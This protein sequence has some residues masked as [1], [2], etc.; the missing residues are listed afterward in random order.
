MILKTIMLSGAVAGLV[1]MGP[2]LC[3]PELHKYGDTFPTGHRLHRHRHRPAR[4]QQPGRHRL[5]RARVG[6]LERGGAGPRRRS[7]CP[8]RSSRSCRA[9][10]CSPSSSPSRWCAATPAPPP[11]REAAAQTAARR[12]APAA[13]RR[14]DH[15]RWLA[16]GEPR[17][18]GAAAWLDEPAGPRPLVVRRR[19]PSPSCR[20]SRIIAD[21][22]DLTQR[23]HVRRRH[24]RLGADRAGRPRRPLVRAGR[25]RQHRPR[26][27][28][29]PRHLVRRLGRLAVGPV[30]GARC[31]GAIGGALGGAAPRPRHGH[32]RRRPHRRPASPST[33]SRPASAGSCRACC[34]SA[35]GDGTITQSPHMT[36]D[37]G[38]LTVP[39]LSGGSFFGWTRPTR[40][41]GSTSN[42]GSSS[43]TSPA[44][45]RASPPSMAWTTV[46]A[47]AAD[48]AHGLRAVAHARSGC[49]C[50]P[51]AR[52]RAPPTRSA[53]PSTAM[54][55]VGRHRSPGALAGLG[56]AWLAIDVRAYNQDQIAGRG[57]HGLAAMIF[58]NWRPL[59]IVRRRRRCSATPRRSP[60]GSARRRCSPC[61][62]WPTIVVRRRSAL[63]L[64]TKGQFLG[65]I[66]ALAVAALAW[67]V[68]LPI[69]DEVN[70]QLVFITPYVV[71]LSC[72]PSPRSACARRPR[73]ASRGARAWSS[74]WHVDWDALRAAAVA[75]AERRLRA[76][77]PLPRRGGRAR[78]RRPGRH[79]AATSRTRRTAST[80]CAECGL[81]S[82]LHATGGGRLVAVVRVAGDGA[83]AH[84]V[85]ALPPA[86]VGARRPRLPGRRRRH[87][88]PDARA[89]ARRLRRAATIEGRTS[90]DGSLRRGRRHPRQARRRP[91]SPTTQ[92]DWVIDAYT[93]RRRSPT[94]RCRRSPWPIFFRRHG[95]P[96]SSPRWTGGDDRHRRAA[97][98]LRR[99]A[100]R[101]S[102]STPPAA[103]ATRSRCRCARWWPP[104]ARPCRSCPA[105]GSATP[106]A[107]STSWSR[108]RAGGPTLSPDEMLGAAARRRRRHLRRRRRPGPGRP[109]AV[110]AARRHRHGRDASR[111]SPARS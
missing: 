39:F 25:R 57:F 104:A 27:H 71:T 59:G 35:Q 82:A 38:T 10:C 98:L 64:C 74:T 76:L 9:R 55:Y 105:A 88:A 66:V 109:Q 78:R 24:R 13:G 99:S 2:L 110:R 29:D 96:A 90:R 102:T 15:R 28:D 101:R 23:A 86:A 31:A 79:A 97:R 53:S 93:A 72:W 41:A 4:P 94:S 48:P 18:S 52:S 100:G 106:A 5:R 80:L 85:R 44:C 11:V 34:S 103:S 37:I 3:D 19:R 69:T 40:S 108:S 75:A 8:R 42:G 65:G 45:S 16:A 46:V 77:L 30:G 67:C 6:C 68:L 50:G 47:L 70:N 60:S 107:R 89:A 17:R 91:R 111:S 21:A 62:S 20:S 36:G 83:A 54:Q 43:P 1:G 95:P 73:T 61:S 26:G 12:D 7:A 56:G 49:G 51:P 32:V 84:A 87:A 63:R 92:I 33:S 22:P 58:G 81:V 14:H